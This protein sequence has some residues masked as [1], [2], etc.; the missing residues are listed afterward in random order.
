MMVQAIQGGRRAGIDQKKEVSIH[1]LLE[2]AF[3]RECA[4]LDFAE[5]GESILGYGYA[6]MTA[7]ILRHE[8]LGCRIDGG[9][10]S[11]PHP[12]ADA[13]AAAVSALPEARGGRRMA[14]W[15]AELARA[16]AVPDWMPDA[17]PRVY[18]EDMYV[19]QHG[20]VAKTK[21]AAHLGA[22]GWPAQPR[23]N[24]KGVIVMDPVTYC[25]IVIRPTAAHIARRRRDYLDWWG[26]L[27]EIKTTFQAYGGLSA[28]TVSNDMPPRAPW[29][30]GLT[31]GEN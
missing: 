8:Q 10:R 13:V 9:G 7:M 23:R 31:Q 4:R 5:D 28:Y 21:D 6:S 12:D 26:A 1:A 29:Q 18:P 17:A 16:G 19:N 24:R 22:S 15:I 2:W 20:S 30:R 14:V 11:E 27:M 3:R 25:P